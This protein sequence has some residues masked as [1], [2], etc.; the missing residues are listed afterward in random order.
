MQNM[1]SALLFCIL[2]CILLHIHANQY[3]EYAK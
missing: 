3:A 1:D 2:F